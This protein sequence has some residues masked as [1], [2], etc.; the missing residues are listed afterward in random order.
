M[1]KKIYEII[2]ATNNKSTMLNRIYNFA[3]LLC[4]IISM[5]PLM[6]KKGSELYSA[7]NTVTLI[8]FLIDYILRLITADYSMEKGVK[9]FFIYPFTPMAIIDLISILPFIITMSHGF[10]VLRL[11]RIIKTL[12]VFRSFKIFRYSRNFDRIVKVLKLE[13]KPLLAVLSLALFYVLFTSLT[14]FSIEPQT[15]ETFFD[16][17]YWSV[18]S[19][20]SIGY[21][22]IY[23][24][25]DIGRAFTVISAIVGVAIIALPSGII[26]AGY[27]EILREDKGKK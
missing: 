6:D 15:F 12:R 24:V 22:D 27:M 4:I 9:S 11:L 16:A 18:I 1:R 20:T 19:L 10:R 17:V 25:S 8:V 21:G 13:A 26:T 2:E 3:M 14:M 5:I 7:I 23:P